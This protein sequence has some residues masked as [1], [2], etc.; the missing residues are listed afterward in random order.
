VKDKDSLYYWNIIALPVAGF[1]A[2]QAASLL[3]YSTGL[4]FYALLLTGSFVSSAYIGWI[5]VRRG[6]NVSDSCYCG[7]LFGLSIGTI[8]ALLILDLLTSRRRVH[9]T[10]LDVAPELIGPIFNIFINIVPAHCI[11][12]GAVSMLSGLVAKKTMRNG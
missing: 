4:P 2:L 7:M 12:T 1:V 3:I 6:G 5:T 8:P 11:A 9:T 10:V